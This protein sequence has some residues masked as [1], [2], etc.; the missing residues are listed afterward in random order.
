[1]FTNFKTRVTR[2]KKRISIEVEISPDEPI[3]YNGESCEIANLTTVR[4]SSYIFLYITNRFGKFYSQLS[5]KFFNW[6]YRQQFIRIYHLIVIN[7]VG[8][9]RRRYRGNN[10]YFKNDDNNTL[11][12][13]SRSA[14]LNSLSLETLTFDRTPFTF[15]PLWLNSLI[16]RQ[17]TTR[18]ITLVKIA[19]NPY[20]FS[21]TSFVVIDDI[22][23]R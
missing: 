5:I 1:M 9:S 8:M 20:K 19:S 23:L 3:F 4:L 16:L 7:F 21:I 15:I 13:V 17:A 22:R 2:E 6:L 10:G 12:C 11:H 14:E 18:L